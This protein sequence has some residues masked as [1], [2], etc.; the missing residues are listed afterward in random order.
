MKS[1]SKK[2]QI[3]SIIDYTKLEIKLPERVKSTNIIYPND[4]YSSKHPVFGVMN[5]I[6]KEL[7]FRIIDI[8]K[9]DSN[10]LI[11]YIERLRQHFVKIWYQHEHPIIY[12][13]VD[14][15]DAVKELQSFTSKN[16]IEAIVNNSVK[17]LTNEFADMNYIL[18]GNFKQATCLQVWFPEMFL[19]EVNGKSLLGSILNGKQFRKSM[20]AL[21]RRIYSERILTNAKLGQKRVSSVL[22]NDYRTV[23]RNQPVNNFPPHIQKWAIE[24]TYPR[25]C[26][27]DEFYV[28]DL[29]MGWGGRLIGTLG[30]F[31][32]E[33]FN[34]K[35]IGIW[36][37]DPN[38]DVHDRFD[39]I[40]EIWKMN[41]DPDISRL[42]FYKSTLPAE[43]ILSDPKFSS[44][45]GKF[46]V[47]LTSPPYYN[48]EKYSKNSGQS[49]LRYKSYDKWSRD[50]LKE[51]IKNTHYLL[52]KEVLFFL[53]IANI[54]NKSTPRGQLFYPLERDALR[55]AVNAGF[56]LKETV[57]YPLRIQHGTKKKIEGPNKPKYIRTVQL[58]NGIRRCEPIFIFEK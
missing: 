35:K 45:K 22:M 21:F 29:C 11:S 15:D 51:M 26:N 38:T 10:Q 8:I 31:A 14:L 46:S 40:I 56:V 25:F 53:N 9:F 18:Q 47:M 27:D 7:D 44:M 43:D 39:K 52:K 50:F 24:K 1:S 13:G 54:F 16:D 5:V 32:N 37:T 19:A 41:I 57:L 49:F 17:F 33:N 34:N 3:D 28:L 30:A 42:D 6:P 36:G 55:Y 20:I 58:K 12:K 23:N 4:K 48:K 2:Y